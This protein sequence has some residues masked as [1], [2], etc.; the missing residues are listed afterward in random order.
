[1]LLARPPACGPARRI[2]PPVTPD[3]VGLL[4]E[5]VTEHL[6][7]GGGNGEHRP[8]AIG[9][10]EFSGIGRLRRRGGS[11][12]VVD[13]LERLV[14][15]AQESCR[16]YAVSF[17]ETDI[18]P[19]GGK[20]LLVAGAP[21]GVDDPAEALLCT[22]RQVMDDPGELS[23]RAGVTT[24]RVFTGC[25]GPYF[26]RGYSV[27]GD[28]VNLAARIMGKAPAGA[29]WCLPTVTEASRTRFALEPVPPFAVKGKQAP[30]TV[31]AVGRTLRREGPATDLPLVGRAVEIAAVDGALERVR[32]GAGSALEV[33]GDTGAGKSRLLTEISLRAD[34]LRVIAVAGEPFR[35]ASPYFLIRG[36]L[37]EALGLGRLAG[38]DRPEA[39]RRWVEHHRPD[40]AVWLPLF[41]AV[42]QVPFGRSAEADDIAPEFRAERLRSVML[43]LLATALPGPT[44]LL[45]DDVQY[46]DPASAEMLR[47]LARVAGEQ[48]WLVVVSH[49]GESAPAG[50]AANLPQLRLEPL[51]DGAATAL[52]YA[53][54]DDAP[55]PPHVL[56][57]VVARGSGNPLFL[58]QLARTARGMADADELPDSVESVVSARIDRLPPALREVLRAAAVMGLHVDPDL[59]V[60]LL[61]AE[62]PA[63]A[64]RATLD[65]LAEF[66]V[67]DRAELRFGQAVVR[68]SAYDG[69][70][71]R[72][73][74]ALHG[75]LA[76]LMDARAEGE[77]HGASVRSLHHFRAGNLE[78]ALRLSRLA[79]E[80]AAQSGAQA[81]T[82]TLLGRAIESARRLGAVPAR[83][84]AELFERLADAQMRLGELDAADRS[85]AAARRLLAA[86]PEHRARIGMKTARTAT[87]RGDFALTQRRLRRVQGLLA[88]VPE[89]TATDLLVESTMRV[90]FTQLRQ[91][92]LAEA[93]RTCLRVLELGDPTRQPGAIADALGHVDLIDSQ[94]GRPTGSRSRQALDLYEKVAGLSG[95][96]AIYNQLGIQAFFAGRWDDALASYRRSEELHAR[97]GDVN[98]V[99][100]DSANIAEIL[101]GQGRLDEAETALRSAIRIWRSAG[102]D[103]EIAFGSALLG[104]VLA[105]RSDFDEAARL[106]S[107]ARD[108]FVRQGAR[109]EV[110]DADAYQAELLALQGR[111]EAALERA[112]QT[113]AAAQRVSQPP[114]QAPLLHRIIAWCLDDLGQPDAADAAFADALDAARRVK[115]HHEVAF[116]VAAIASR[117]RRRGTTV[118][119]ALVLEAV[120]LQRRL[121]VVIDLDARVATALPPTQRVGGDSLTTEH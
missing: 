39:L 17:H 56:V 48:P 52:V 15:L 110:V 82:V 102:A 9:F 61:A 23:L 104:R 37:T 112:R 92:R 75:R 90:A 66:L 26:R 95:Q 69:L 114:T 20:I 28:A 99:A 55:L 98:C 91:G 12:A 40:L 106:L 119:P 83:E 5:L 21:H 19:D 65:R 33:V 70:P 32:T 47:V 60:D 111:S 87:L 118:D 31:M 45:V 11:R 63:A 49:R 22:L 16:R 10:L 68:D 105:Q 74:V 43:E 100:I 25:V 2:D 24:G 71:Y 51:S 96:A 13:A 44:V 64:I 93:R 6:I 76:A 116:T 50:A 38:P 121:G 113:L 77:A 97:L 29:L 101:L 57:A 35:S 89:P 62:Q 108:R 103:N 42:F 1:V 84:R 88:S 81:E 117:A 109:S 73:R 3:V 115:A 67:T 41:S 58:R 72:R 8:V 80:R 27:K 120:P 7:A 46:A 78:A 86:D 18:A 94:L 34:G 14:D 59:L 53:D 30:V 107:D 54:T 79:A 4:P 85:F 36:L